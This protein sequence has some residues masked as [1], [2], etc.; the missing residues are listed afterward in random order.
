MVATTASCAAAK[1]CGDGDV[2]KPYSL[3]LNPTVPAAKRGKEFVGRTRVLGKGF[4]RNYLGYLGCDSGRNSRV[5]HAP[6]GGAQS[7]L[8]LDSRLRKENPPPS[9]RLSAVSRKI[10]GWLKAEAQEQ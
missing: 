4:G 9:Y 6:R 5:D 3:C 8:K 7:C 10:C 1:G 2:P